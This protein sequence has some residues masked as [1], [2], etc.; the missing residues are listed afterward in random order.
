MMEK[1]LL[2]TNLKQGIQL[3]CEEKWLDKIRIYLF[4]SSINGVKYNHDIDI[5]IVY[6]K[7]HIKG[8]DI[9]KLRRD[10]F[11]YWKI[12][13]DSILDINV[14]SNNEEKELRFIKR[15]KAEEILFI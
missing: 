9:I 3:Y 5:I 15:T 7:E 6:N 12:H 8:S 13:F 14:F 2:I 11:N 1:S 4:G 10:I